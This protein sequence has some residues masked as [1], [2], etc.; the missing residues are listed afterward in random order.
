[1]SLENALHECTDGYNANDDSDEENDDDENC[2]NH[3]EYDNPFS[4]TSI[5]SAATTTAAI[6]TSS[7]STTTS[8]PARMILMATATMKH[9]NDAEDQEKQDESTNVVRRLAMLTQP[10]WK[11]ITKL[12][13]VACIDQVDQ[14]SK[15]N[16]HEL[17]GKK[18]EQRIT[19][20]K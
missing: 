1:M 2:A 17:K 13:V 11:Q 9:A 10:V 3:E 8:W 19:C 7:T 15:A 20:N 18:D 14:C 16:D 4:T 12:V 6:P 5:S